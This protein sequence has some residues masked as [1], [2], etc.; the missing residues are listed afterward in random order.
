[1]NYQI[2]SPAGREDKCQPITIDLPLTQTPLGSR[3][4]SDW[5]DMKARRALE[6]REAGDD[7]LCLYLFSDCWF[8]ENIISQLITLER[9][10]AVKDRRGEVIA[11]LGTEGDTDPENLPDK[12]LSA[13]ADSFRILY[14]WDLLRAH[15][16]A[17][18]SLS[19]SDLQGDV[20][21]LAVIE[22][23]AVVGA[24]TRLLPGV[25][26]EGKV[27]IGKN[28]KIGPNCYLRG[29]TS[30]GDNCHIGQA[31]EIKNSLIMNGCSLGHLSYCGDSILAEKVNF[32]AGTIT[33]NLRHDN[34]DHRSMIDGQL[35]NTERRKF[36]TV[37]GRG[38]H[39]GIHTSIYP[40]RKFWPSTGTRPGAIVE[41]DV[42]E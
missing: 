37:V 32:G 22:G 39:T 20:S 25:F 11:W 29:G 4:L 12:V 26:I 15:E 7:D 8:S 31:V 42:M 40:G 17:V 21:P 10:G 5:T 2:F 13:D 6:Q 23:T 19:E 9:P 28:C 18:G 14:P 24:G 27:V 33:A 38:V 34:G 3:V 35:V 30:I 36:G 1:M 16:L 41:K